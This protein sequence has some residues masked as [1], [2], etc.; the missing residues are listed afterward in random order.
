MTATDTLPDY[1][2]LS[3]EIERCGW[4]PADP[5]PLN[6]DLFFQTAGGGIHAPARVFASER[7]ERLALIDLTALQFPPREEL[8]ARFIDFPMEVRLALAAASRL[9]ACNLVLLIQAGAF[10]L[11]SLPAESLA[12]R[13]TNVREF[14]DEM[15]PAL[16]ARTIHRGEALSAVPNWLEAA[17]T[18]RGWLSH[19]GRLLADAL[20][21]E[22]EDCQRWVWKIILMLQVSRATGDGELGGGWGLACERLGPAWSLS[23]DSLGTHEDLGRRLDEFEQTFSSRIFSGDAES[24]RARL[25]RLEETSLVEQL[26]AELLMQSRLRFE[27]DCVAWLFASMEREQEGWRRE[28]SG[29]APLRR[30]LGADGWSVLAPL[31]CDVAA[32]GLAALLRD[33][34]RLAQYWTE[35]DALGARRE[36]RSAAEIYSQPDLFRGNPRGVSPAGRLDDPVN[37]VLSESIR[38]AG[39]APED[40]FG[41]GI[42]ILLKSLGLVGRLDWPFFGI[43]SL[44]RVWKR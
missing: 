1:N 33:L 10:E 41:V 43:D 34:D 12:Y 35:F 30:R 13:A 38:V 44:D 2:L 36:S 37:F 25:A 28:V 23:Y 6:G 15:L 18:L 21:E 17:E 26:R 7:G 24:D 19:W 8:F 40:E 42:V 32:H 4:R 31:E 22:S 20:G 27:P 11:Y 9:A 29:L 16:A 3:R 5:P 14:E 39:A